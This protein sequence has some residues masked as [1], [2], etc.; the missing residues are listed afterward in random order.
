MQFQKII[1]EKVEVQLES[2][3]FY[4]HKRLN[5]TLNLGQVLLGHHLAIN[6]LL[7]FCI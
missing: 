6:H 5:L 4:N 7:G 2:E 3:S 1:V